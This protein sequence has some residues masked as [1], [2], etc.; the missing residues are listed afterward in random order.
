MN[1]FARGEQRWDPEHRL[2]W[3]HS[4]G[5]RLLILV[6]NRSYPDDRRVAAE[7]EALSDAGYDVTVVCPTAART[8]ERE[9]TLEGVRVLRYEAPPPGHGIL[10]YSR[11]YLLALGGM[12][13]I[14]RRLRKEPQFAAVIACNPPDVLILLA[15]LLAR[16]NPGLVFDYHD[17]SPEL[18]EEVFGRRGTLYRLLLR[19]ERLAFRTADVVMTV[20]EPC[21]DLVRGRGKVPGSRVFVVCNCPDPRRFFPVDPRPELRQGCEHLVLWIGTMSGRMSRKEGL[22][23]LLEAAD[24]LVNK[25][26]RTDVAFSIVGGGDIQ[27]ELAAEIKHRGLDSVVNLP[28]ELGLDHIREYIATADVCVSLDKRTPMT[29]QALVV[30]VLEYMAMGRPVV[31]FP[32]REMRRICGDT[33]VYTQNGDFHDLAEMVGELL[34]DP[35]RRARLGKA[36][37]ERVLEGLTWPDQIPTLLHAVEQAIASR[38]E[39]SP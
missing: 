17:L 12:G 3:R 34:D 38:H 6:E 10:G 24:E 7:A 11:E 9:V 36:A 20:N 26:G 5:K 4:I 13:R 23:L 39:G 14:L 31:Q 16:G 2:A 33:T 28:G 32:L 22:Y 21:A 18:F 35:E 27:N 29:D 19:V 30:K 1:R 37:R 15:R 25:R 8:P